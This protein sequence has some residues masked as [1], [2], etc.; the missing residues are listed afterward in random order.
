MAHGPVHCAFPA[1]T[2]LIFLLIGF[3]TGGALS[4]FVIYSNILDEDIGD[5]RVVLRP[6]QNAVTSHSPLAT[7]AAP[8]G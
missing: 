1:V 8:L 4:L 5:F 2:R 3:V 7:D 6:R